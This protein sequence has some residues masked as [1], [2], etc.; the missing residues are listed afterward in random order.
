MEDP[1]LTYRRLA[2]EC[3]EDAEAFDRKGMSRLAETS[4]KF[5]AEYEQR[6]AE[7]EKSSKL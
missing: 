5:A 7:A 3:H 1:I 4:L 6:L 2:R